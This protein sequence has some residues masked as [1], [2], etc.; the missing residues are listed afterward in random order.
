MKRFEYQAHSVKKINDL[1]NIL[2]GMSESGWEPFREIKARLDTTGCYPD[3]VTLLFR[4]EL[5]EQVNG[6]A[7]AKAREPVA[8]DA[9]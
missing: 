9:E 1:T 4:R 7:S 6:K 2:N 3:G 5:K 8:A